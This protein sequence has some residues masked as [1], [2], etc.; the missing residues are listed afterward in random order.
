MTSLIVGQWGPWTH[1]RATNT[2]ICRVSDS[3]D[4]EVGI[5]ETETAADTVSW[6]AQLAG[7]TWAEENPEI[8]G[9]FLLALD[10]LGGGL[11]QRMKS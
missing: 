4:Y 5:E 10:S 9:Y 7:K 11:H 1:D 2:L 8:L 3:Y 6:L